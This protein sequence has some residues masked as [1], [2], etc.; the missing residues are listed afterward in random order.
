VGFTASEPGIRRARGCRSQGQAWLETGGHYQLIQPWR[1]SPAFVIWRL[2][3]A[4]AAGIAAWLFLA[5]SLIFSG[6][7]I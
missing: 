7:C 3:Q 4:P 5:G 1:C 2:L 6:S